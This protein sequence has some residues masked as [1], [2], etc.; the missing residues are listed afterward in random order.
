MI[1]VAANHTHPNAASL[2]TSVAIEFEKVITNNNLVPYSVS[3]SSRDK[4]DG[5]RYFYQEKDLD[6]E[7]RNMPIG[8]QHVIMMI[9]VDYYVDINRWLMYG[10]PI[11]LYTFV[12]VIAGGKVADALFHV[13]NDTVHYNISGGSTYTHQLWDYTGDTVSVV[14]KSGTLIT[15][16]IEQHLLDADP[17]RRI[18]GFYPTSYI[19][20]PYYKFVGTAG[21]GVSRRKLT[22][23]NATVVTCGDTISVAANSSPISV[24]VPRNVYET[25]SIRNQTSARPGIADVERLLITNKVDD[26]SNC[27]PI[28]F[29]LLNLKSTET[30]LTT[31]LP[32]NLRSKQPRHVT[33]QTLDP[34]V[35]EDG[36]PTGRTIAPSIV[37][38]PAAYPVRSHNNDTA[39]IAMR[40]TNI[41]N[42]TVP[43]RQYDLYARE[44]VQRMTPLGIGVPY[45]FDEVLAKQNKPLQKVRNELAI[46]SLT[47]QAPNKLKTFLKSEPCV[48]VKAPR[49]IT[50]VSTDHTLR[51][52]RFTYAFKEHVLQKT[53][54]F[55]PGMTPLEVNQRISEVVDQGAILRDYSN[56]DGT[57]SEF[58]Q[59]NIV[60]AMYLRYYPEEHHSELRKI[61]I[62]EHP[63][64]ATTKTGIHYEPGYS[65]KS[66][67]PATTDGNTPINAFN[68]FAALRLLGYSVDKAWDTLGLYC[69]D[70]GVD[71]S[72]TGFADALKRVSTDLGLTLKITEIERGDPISFCSR[73]F[74]DPITTTTSFCDPFRALAKLH[75]S[76]NA[77]ATRQ[78]AAYNKA[79]GYL[80]T[81]ALTPIIGVWCR[82]V[83][84]LTQLFEVKNPTADE[85]FKLD[86][87]PWLQC[88]E[89]LMMKV[90]CDLT[91]LTTSEVQFIEDRIKVSTSLDDLPESYIDN[92]KQFNVT[93]D[94]VI[95]DTIVH[96]TLP[97]CTSAP[98]TSDISTSQCP[99]SVTPQ[100][101][102]SLPIAAAKQESC[103]SSKLCDSSRIDDSDTLKRESPS[104][105]TLPPTSIML[106]S[107]SSS[108]STLVVTGPAIMTSPVHSPTVTLTSTATQPISSTVST[109]SS[110]PTD[111]NAT[112]QTEKTLLSSTPIAPITTSPTPKVPLLA[113]PISIPP[114]TSPPLSQ[115]QKNLLPETIP[116]ALTQSEKNRLRR[117]RKQNAK[118]LRQQ[119]TQSSSTNKCNGSPA[120][121]T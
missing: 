23:D 50:T 102:S 47:L 121:S 28:L 8:P 40:V 42:T 48:G 76:N 9:D 68:A 89:D 10:N 38:N 20:Y 55:S 14:D 90:F 58:L 29:N 83:I 66:G 16:K 39:S 62:N 97:S 93:V 81:D 111:L 15:Y 87:G 6:K 107:C 74:C 69:G 19:K 37:T 46:P 35:N 27:A 103:T 115:S 11:L 86:A 120:T 7:Y 119:A 99:T 112:L 1:N 79:S 91:E 24:T 30:P 82:K 105:S 65:T 21:K 60:Q 22:Y 113:T 32:C 72:L 13:T 118:R 4:Y 2:R 56:Y 94:G 18:I 70:D 114:E 78:Q 54:W 61:F 109:D 80:A 53:K 31:S 73:I 26:A 59:K 84:E 25:I 92:S 75:L 106:P 67:S 64:T 98:S 63:R 116:P 17:N 108:C 44:F 3:M 95:N 57:I 101:S 34:L 117:L 12:P 85:K 45:G 41:L 71:Q 110:T 96:P 49:N 104:T 88:D 52:S 77:N 5:C 43:S 36:Q 33:Y 51:Y 100:P